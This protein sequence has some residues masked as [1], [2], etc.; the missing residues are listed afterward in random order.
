[1]WNSK[2][3]AF[4][5]RLLCVLALLRATAPGLAAS[6][7]A[8]P[9]QTCAAAAMAPGIVHFPEMSLTL[10]RRV[11]AKLPYNHFLFRV[12][13]R[14][15]KAELREYLTKVYNV[16]VARITTAISL[17]E[18]EGARRGGPSVSRWPSVS[19]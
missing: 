5:A 3:G 10:V 1:M 18:E 7:L 6:A 15:T 14:H 12:D 4:A 17:G 9:S 2:S 19:R 8:Q 11:S 16:N 13:P